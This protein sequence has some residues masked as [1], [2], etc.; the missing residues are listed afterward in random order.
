MGD[1]PVEDAP[2]PLTDV[3]KWVLSQTDEEFKKHGWE[4]LKEIIGKKTCCPGFC[5]RWHLFRL[6]N[7]DTRDEQAGGPEEEAVRLASIHEMDGRNQG[8]VW[9]HD[10]IPPREPPAQAMGRAPIHPEVSGPV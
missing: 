4:E 1:V 5:M 9:L 7:H 2:F 10:Q 3:D 6:S 8:R